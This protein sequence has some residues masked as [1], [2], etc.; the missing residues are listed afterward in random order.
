MLDDEDM[1]EIPFTAKP[2][3]RVGQRR[4]E[5][6]LQSLARFRIRRAEYRDARVMAKCTHYRSRLL[7]AFYGVEGQYLPKDGIR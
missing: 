7:R 6:A 2:P 5:T 1:S 4:G 3:S